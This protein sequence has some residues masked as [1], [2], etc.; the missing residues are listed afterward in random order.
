MKRI[1]FGRAAERGDDRLEALLEVAAIPRARQERAG[2][3]REDFRILQRPL[4]IVVQ[5]PRGEALGHGG[6]A[7]ARIADEHRVVLAAAAEHFDRP[8]ELLGASDQRI[9][10]SLTRP[11]G[12]VDAVRLERIG[13]ARAPRRRRRRSSGPAARERRRAASGVFVMPCEM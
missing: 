2:V 4:H 13:R 9:E 11:F 1:G 10:Q 7:D 3:E 6:L 12:Q 5:Q 8:L